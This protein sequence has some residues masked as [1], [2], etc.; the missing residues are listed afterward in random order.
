MTP[1]QVQTFTKQSTANAL[2][3]NSLRL[4]TTRPASR[5][6]PIVG[7]IHIQHTSITVAFARW[8]FLFLG[9]KTIKSSSVQVKSLLVGTHLT[10]AITRSI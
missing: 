3:V 10:I 6:Q 7:W 2:W 9:L 5:L 8:K 4:L 1:G